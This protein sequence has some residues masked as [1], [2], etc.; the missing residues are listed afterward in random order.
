MLQDQITASEGHLE[1]SIS[2][3]Q[4]DVHQIEIN[5]TTLG[6]NICQVDSKLT[7]FQKE[8]D[9]EFENVDSKFL[10]LDSKIVVDKKI[11]K[12]NNRLDSLEQKINHID[13][14]VNSLDSSVNS[15][16]TKLDNFTIDQH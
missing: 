1:N 4:R 13:D 14:K 7:S 16:G 15:I 6:T 10:N 9:T 2:T 11:D 8:G 5:T 3:F 12:V